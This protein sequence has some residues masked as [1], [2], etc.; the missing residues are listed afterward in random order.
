MRAHAALDARRTDLDGRK[1]ALEARLAEA[2]G[3][4][5]AEIDKALA[6]P[7]GGNTTPA[8]G[9]HSEIVAASSPT[10]A[11]T[12]KWVQVDLGREIAITRVSSRI[13]WSVSPVGSAAVA[14]AQT[15]VAIRETAVANRR[16]AGG[17]DGIAGP[18]TDVGDSGTPLDAAGVLQADVTGRSRTGVSW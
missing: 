1:K 4:R 15:A 18:L 5:L 6:A 7:G 17:A 12:E 14:R 16:T 13:R 9:W 3:A 10:A 11:D 8:F 2:A